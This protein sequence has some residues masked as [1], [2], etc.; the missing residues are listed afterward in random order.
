MAEG[1]GGEGHFTIISFKSVSN[2]GVMRVS[3]DDNLVLIGRDKPLKGMS[4]HHEEKR[5]GH[6]FFHSLSR[7]SE[8]CSRLR[9]A[10]ITV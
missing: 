6:K 8:N 1:K 2:V 3:F 7:R 9:S 4:D 5:L 10:S